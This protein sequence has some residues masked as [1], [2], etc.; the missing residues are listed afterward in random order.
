LYRYSEGGAED[1][2]DGGVTSTTFGEGPE[3][4]S[5]DGMSRIFRDDAD[6]PV[7]PEGEDV[8]AWAERTRSNMGRVVCSF[9]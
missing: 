8:A 2:E 4:D 7:P 3:Y 1:S 5:A 6:R 9:E